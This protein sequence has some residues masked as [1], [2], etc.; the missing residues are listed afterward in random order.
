MPAS[1]MEQLRAEQA[2]AASEGRPSPPPEFLTFVESAFTSRAEYDRW[3]AEMEAGRE[4]A[5]G[6][7]T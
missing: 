7:R 3:A 1:V 6:D 4:E 5:E 2:A